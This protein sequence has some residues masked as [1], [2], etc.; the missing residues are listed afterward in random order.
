MVQHWEKWQLE[1][2]HTDS[3]KYYRCFNKKE[4]RSQIKKEKRE[5]AYFRNRHTWF[6]IK[7][8]QKKMDHYEAKMEVH[9]EVLSAL[10]KVQKSTYGIGGIEWIK[11]F[12]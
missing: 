4:L 2:F 6:S 12:I 9:I 5:M 8:N 7:N 3:L 1:K 10:R 11:N